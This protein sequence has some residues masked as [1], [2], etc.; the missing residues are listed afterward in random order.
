MGIQALKQD[1]RTVET[2]AKNNESVENI[3]ALVKRMNVV[4]ENCIMQLETEILQ[5]AS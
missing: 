5:K 2:T 1:V 4:V 3:P